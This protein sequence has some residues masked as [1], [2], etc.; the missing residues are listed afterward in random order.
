MADRIKPPKIT[1]VK[2]VKTFNELLAAMADVYTPGF[3]NVGKHIGYKVKAE[4][5]KD[6]HEIEEHMYMQDALN[7]P[8]PRLDT[9]EV[10][11]YSSGITVQQGTVTKNDQGVF[12]TPDTGK[13]YPSRKDDPSFPAPEIPDISPSTLFFTFLTIVWAP[14]N[15][16]IEA[17]YG[18][19][20]A[21][22]WLCYPNLFFFV[23][24]GITHVI[25]QIR[26]MK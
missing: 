26:K 9:S 3:G 13:S 15:W 6:L 2:E 20:P 5:L 24:I 10:S 7:R 17:N 19:V 22:W 23:M 14:A 12:F 18:Y 4:V 1:K 8:N 25:S 16:Y 11:H 21:F